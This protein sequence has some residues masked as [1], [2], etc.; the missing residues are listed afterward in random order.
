MKRNG[1]PVDPIFNGS[2]KLF[3]RFRSEHIASGTFTGVGLSFK[4]DAPSVNRQKYSFPDDVLFTEGGEYANWG[5][6][7]LRVRD[8]PSELPD[9]SPR[10]RIGPRHDPLEDNYA[11]SGIHCEGIPAQGYVEPSPAVRK[12]LRATLGQR[13]KIEIESQV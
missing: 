1:R 8:I 9:G 10:Y 13:I 11:H 2:E 7:S 3:R 5:V 4:D 12:I 6:I